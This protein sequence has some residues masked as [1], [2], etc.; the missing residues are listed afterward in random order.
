MMMAG[1]LRHDEDGREMPTIHSDGVTRSAMVSACGRYRYMLERSTGVSG[2]NLAWLM[3]NPSTADAQLDD[4]TIRKVIGFSARAGYGIARVVNLFA[5]RATDPRDVARMLRV[6]PSRSPDR[7]VRLRAQR[8]LA[9]GTENRAAIKTVASMSD[10]VVCAWGAHPWAREQAV[11]VVRW[12]EDQKLLCLGLS[13]AGDPLHPLMPSYDGHPLV[14]YDP[15][16]TR[17][18]DK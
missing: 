13:K 11:R 7:L 1:D 9:E 4:P 18:E 8:A 5:W 15:R 16:S 3:L 17:A 10:A 6:T 12:L 14:V 2:P